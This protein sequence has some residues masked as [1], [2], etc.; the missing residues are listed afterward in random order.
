[1]K[2]FVVILCC[3]LLATA[4]AANPQCAAGGIKHPDP[5]NPACCAASCGV[6]HCGTVTCA[7]NGQAANCCSAG[8]KAAA[9]SCNTFNAPCVR[10]SS[11]VP[12]LPQAPRTCAQKGGISDS[13]KTV[14]CTGR[15]GSC[16]GNNCSKRAGGSAGC[17]AGAIKASQKMCANG[18]TAPPCILSATAV[19]K[20][21]PPITTVI[22]PSKG[23]AVRRNVQIGIYPGNAKPLAQR[24]AEYG[25][26]VD[27]VLQ[28][29]S[30]PFLDH[31]KIKDLLN[32]QHK[33]ILVSAICI[34]CC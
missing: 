20:P 23:G 3:S 24:E 32:S 30:V 29:Q 7:N 18:N 28:F 26:H 1:M 10:S 25:V 12:L 19:A 33:V 2:R 15:C 21:V 17:C 34:H 9:K 8:I 4:W 13:A 14:C 22:P 16:G 6:Q 31:A 27:H 5:A 11:S